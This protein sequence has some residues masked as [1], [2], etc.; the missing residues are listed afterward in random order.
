MRCLSHF[1]YNSS[2]P[3]RY[4]I[5]L[6]KSSRIPRPL[7]FVTLLE[8]VLETTVSNLLSSPLGAQKRREEICKDD[9]KGNTYSEQQSQDTKIHL[10][11]RSWMLQFL[12]HNVRPVWGHG[13]DSGTQWWESSHIAMTTRVS[14]LED[15]GTFFSENNAFIKKSFT[16]HI[17]H[18]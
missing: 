18:A 1:L 2:I 10:F 7:W 17:I 9:C 6:A 15:G 8:E 14:T 12:S 16:H 5:P 4:K 13:A 11:F 3:E